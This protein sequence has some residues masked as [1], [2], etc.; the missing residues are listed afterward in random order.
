MV[1]NSQDIV[2]ELNFLWYK[3]AMPRTN[4]GLWR[5]YGHSIELAII[6]HYSFYYWGIRINEI[7]DIP[8]SSMMVYPDSVQEMLHCRKCNQN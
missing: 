5:D 3:I 8:D 6:M 1:G 7:R 4:T 2:R